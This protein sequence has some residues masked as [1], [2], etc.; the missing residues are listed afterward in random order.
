MQTG[1][2]LD[3]SR[4][5][6]PQMIELERLIDRLARWGYGWLELY[7]EHT[8]AFAGHELVWSDASPLTPEEVRQLDAYA[9][10]QG[11]ELRPNFNTLG[12]W[13]RWLKH[14]EYRHLA[15]CPFGWTRPDG[16]GMPHGSTLAPG[17][18]A[19]AMLESLLA[20]FL[21]H[22]SSGTVNLGGDEPWELGMGKSRERC[23]REG[24]HAVY[25][26]HLA[27]VAQLAQVNGKRPA[28]WAD[29]VMEAP[30]VIAQLPPETRLLIWGYEAGEPWAER[31]AA[32]KAAGR[33]AIVCPGTSGWN[34][35]L[36]RLDTATTNLVEAI[37]A[38]RHHQAAEVLVTEWGDFGHHQFPWV[39]AIPLALAAPEADPRDIDAAEAR[40]AADW[41][42]GGSVGKELAALARALGMVGAL[43][44]SNP[45]NANAL[46][47][48]WRAEHTALREVLP[49][50]PRDIW[51]E[52]R[53]ALQPLQARL[54]ALLK[55]DDL[56]DDQRLTAREMHCNAA[57]AAHA[58][59]RAMAFHPAGPMAGAPPLSALRRDGQIILGAF[60]NLW[61]ARNRPGGLHESST[62]I[63][64]MLASDPTE[65]PRAQRPKAFL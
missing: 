30:E 5:K 43:A 19:E 51:P 26:Q 15:E 55:R 58:C 42:G 64:D 2:M 45:H 49:K 33:E 54:E 13:E 17:P 56:T 50:H 1:Y 53:E 9:A 23:E 62:R 24:R 22:F 21:P 4:T 40:A 38:A 8:F 12:H 57:M 31:L 47:L 7:T 28:F 52:M 48:V 46:H 60:E 20:D 61:L 27:A 10:Q 32:V 44:T 16:H 6:V 35:L 34:S 63:R 3:I 25:I 37:E 36:G 39:T 29:I 65:R 59:H 11:L 41:F 18:E 14:P